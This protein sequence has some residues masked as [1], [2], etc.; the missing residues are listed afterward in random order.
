MGDW[1][2]MREWVAMGVWTMDSLWVWG[3]SGGGKNPYEIFSTRNWN[4]SFSFFSYLTASRSSNLFTVKCI[5]CWGVL[6]LRSVNL[7]VCMLSDTCPSLGSLHLAVVIDRVHP[8]RWGNRCTSTCCWLWRLFRRVWRIG[9]LRWLVFSCVVGVGRGTAWVRAPRPTTHHCPWGWLEAPSWRAATSP[10][11]HRIH[12][13][14]WPGLGRFRWIVRS[15]A[16]DSLDLAWQ[17][18]TVSPR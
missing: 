13:A 11:D 3:L 18:N 2:A 1:V 16:A 14:R 8:P 15:I 17:W 10:A 6:T 9:A 7:L 12:Y 5:A 4:C